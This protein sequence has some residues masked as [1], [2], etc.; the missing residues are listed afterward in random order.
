MV[1]LPILIFVLFTGMISNGKLDAILSSWTMIAV[2]VAMIV[3][4]YV[5]NLLRIS[6]VKKISPALLFS[7]AWQTLLIALSTASSAAAFATNVHDA[8]N[9]LGI[10]KKFVDFGIPIGQVLFKPGFFALLFGMSIGFAESCDISIT[11]PWLIIASITN[12]LLSFAVP[13]VPGGAM[14]GFTIAFTQLG[15][16]MEVMGVALA[17][18]AIADF[19]A[20]ACNVSG[21]QLTMVEVAD[22]LDMLDRE[23]LHK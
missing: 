8:K 4:Y 1:L 2:L 17:V 9:K 7:K 19:P 15:V 18:N 5:L 6:L 23:V 10:D 21:W 13:P 22:S 16:P 20:T 3:V 11:L 12:L 14:M